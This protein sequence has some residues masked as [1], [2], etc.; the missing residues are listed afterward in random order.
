[1]SSAVRLRL[2]SL[3]RSFLLVF[4]LVILALACILGY[5]AITTARSQ[6]ATAEGALRDYASMAAWEFSRASRENLGWVISATFDNLP[7]R[8]RSRELPP[9]DAVVSG[10][11]GAL[12]RSRCECADLRHPMAYFRV[13]LTDSTI[14]VLPD[15]VSIDVLGFLT[16][17]ILTDQHV[18][19]NGRDGI[20]ALPRRTVLETPALVTYAVLRGRNGS[21]VA[22]FGFVTP[23]HAYSELFAD[24]FARRPLL[25]PAIA[26]TQPND[27]L[28]YVTVTTPAGEHAFESS[29]PYATTYSARDSLGPEYAALVV[30]AAV[31]PD[32]ASHLIIGGLPRSRLPVIVALLV[33]TLAMGAAALIQLRR[34]QQLARL[35]QDFVSS[36]SHELRTPLAQIRMFAEL[37]D[38]GKLRSD[39]ERSR[40]T[41]VIN[42]EARRLTH[43]VEKI[44]QFSRLERASVELKVEPLDVA[45]TVAEVIEGFKP[46]AAAH[47]VNVDTEIEKGLW[48]R[49]DRDAL[50]QLLLNLL[51]NAVKYGPSG[52]TVTVAAAQ[53]GHAMRLSVTDQGPGVPVHDRERIWEPYHRLER[54]VN[55]EQTGSGIGLAVVRELAEEHGGRCRLEGAPTG[56]ATFVIELPGATLGPGGTG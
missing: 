34:E 56:G 9:L 18:R 29:I 52:Q 25:P 37:L 1:M 30:E 26:G 46:L 39:S 7:F 15:T 19:E 16:E 48:V 6:R 47:S 13:D 21:A 36:V 49:A 42:R 10:L 14:V 33:L 35:R 2:R 24:W 38:E 22:T 5:H 31:R 54:E 3:S 40:S 43:L 50:S 17:A 8:L 11:D 51:D 20:I 53:V 28:L 45:R 4:L 27:S 44:L 55:G 23:P 41:R 32:A 12:R